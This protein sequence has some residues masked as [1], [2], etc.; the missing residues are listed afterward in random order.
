[1]NYTSRASFFWDSD[2]TDERKDEIIEWAMSLSEN[3][4]EYLSDIIRDVR[5]E[6]IF[7][8]RG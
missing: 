3:E 8:E 5:D 2:L 1:M 4:Q 6:T 7:D